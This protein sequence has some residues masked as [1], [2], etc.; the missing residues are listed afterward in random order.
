MRVDTLVLRKYWQWGCVIFLL[1]MFLVFLNFI[2][3][4]SF[5]KTQTEPSIKSIS[6]DSEYGLNP[7]TIEHA[8]DMLNRVVGDSE[9]F[10]SIQPKILIKKLNAIVFNACVSP[11]V[12]PPENK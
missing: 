1:A 3:K 4:F 2:I 10:C 6:I 9:S 5:I 7:H 12:I 8:R 11:G